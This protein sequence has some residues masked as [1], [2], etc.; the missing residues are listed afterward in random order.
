MSRNKKI[1]LAI[2]ALS[3]I[4][5]LVLMFCLETGMT[6]TFWVT[7]GFVCVAF[8]SSLVFQIITWKNSETLDKQVLHLSGITISSVYALIQIPVGVVFSIGAT[9]I[10]T[11]PTILVNAVL[12]IVAWVLILSSLVGNDHIEKVNSRRKDHHIEL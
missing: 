12:L 7:F 10:S 6:P 4:L 8:V 5:V 9:A 2:W 11:K 1:G 3:L